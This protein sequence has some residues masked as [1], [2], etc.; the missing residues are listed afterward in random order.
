MT[1]NTSEIVRRNISGIVYFTTNNGLVGILASGLVYSRRRLKKEQY[2]QYI[3]HPNAQIRPEEAELF[4]KSVDWLDF[5]NLSISEINQSFFG[6]SQR[7]HHNQEIFWVILSFEPEIL[8]HDGVYFTTTNNSYEHCSREVELV[9]LQAL[10]ANVIRR[11]GTWRAYRGN[12][13]DR[14]PTCQQAEVLY[15]EALPLR[16]LRHIYVNKA[17]DADR[18]RGWLREF[19]VAGVEVRVEPQKFSG[20]PN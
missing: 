17:E 5:V 16:F 11:K 4:D 18:V 7:W 20:V 19:V 13:P 12:R 15:P 1:Q 3:L 6:F 14:L 10:F 2:L 9:G 8:T